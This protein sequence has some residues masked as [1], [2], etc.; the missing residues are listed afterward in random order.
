MGMRTK[1]ERCKRRHERAQRGCQ[2]CDHD[3]RISQLAQ[4]GGGEAC[5]HGKRKQRGGSQAA[6]ERSRQRHQCLDCMTPEAVPS[7][8]CRQLKGGPPEAPDL[9]D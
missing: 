3:K 6:C 1:R 9:L 5:E 8:R 2:A 7:L 4:R